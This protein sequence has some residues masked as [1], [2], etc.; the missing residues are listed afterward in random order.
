MSGSSRAKANP[1][2]NQRDVGKGNDTERGRECPWPDRKQTNT[3]FV[4]PREEE[5]HTRDTEVTRTQ[6]GKDVGRI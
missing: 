2:A 1:A 6:T 5:G 4:K 3:S